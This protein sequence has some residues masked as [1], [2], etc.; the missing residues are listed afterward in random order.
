MGLAVLK[1]TMMFQRKCQKYTASSDRELDAQE[2]VS[3]TS[4]I[5]E[6]TCLSLSSW[7]LLTEDKSTDPD[8]RGVEDVET[9]LQ[10]EEKEDK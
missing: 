3:G 6:C 10:R 9:E 8:N 2:S 1:I 4:R 7:S 5:E